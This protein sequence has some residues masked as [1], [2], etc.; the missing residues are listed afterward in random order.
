MLSPFRQKMKVIKTRSQPSL[1]SQD[2][3]QQSHYPRRNTVRSTY[4]VL[5]TTTRKKDVVENV[6]NVMAHAQKPDFVFRAKRTSP[7][8]SARWEGGGVSSVDCWEPEV[9]AS[10]VVMFDKPCSEVV[11][12]VLAT[13]CIRQFPL[14]FT[15]HASPCAI[16][17]Q[18][19]SIKTRSYNTT[20]ACVVLIH[21]Q[22]SCSK[23]FLYAS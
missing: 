15:P 14:H 7:F 1:H 11:W 6:L 18:L 5:T 20:W 17:F 22:D 4:G 2:I 10:A 3:P 21:R 13:H 19:D 9:C 8:K 16:T 23:L 12:R